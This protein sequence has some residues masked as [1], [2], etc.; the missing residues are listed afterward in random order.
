M[1][2]HGHEDEIFSQYSNE[3]W[4]NYPNFKVG[5]LW[6]LGALKKEP[7]NES[8]IL[9]E[10]ELQNAFFHQLK[11]RSFH[12]ILKKFISVKPLPRKMFLQMDNYV[13][14]NK[15]CHLLTFLSFLIAK[16]MFKECTKT[17]HET[18]SYQSRMCETY[19]APK[20]DNLVCQMREL[21]ICF[22]Y[23]RCLF[24]EMSTKILFV[25]WGKLPILELV[26]IG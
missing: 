9:F 4:P 8:R 3:F 14:D 13:K 5:L 21:I 10:H 20:K 2:A 7:I 16:E 15:N 11:Q 1:I 26:N 25:E 12:Y 19:H 17:Y 6:F 18:K 22:L 24:E 23:L